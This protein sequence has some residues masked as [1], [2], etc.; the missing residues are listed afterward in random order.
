MVH[1]ASTIKKA[2]AI[3]MVLCTFAY[4]LM[5]GDFMV[6][7]SP[8]RFLSLPALLIL[9]CGA[10]FIR[11]R[12]GRSWAVAYLFALPIA[13]SFAG[14]MWI[15]RADPTLSILGCILIA[16]ALAMFAFI[17]GKRDRLWRVDDQQ[18]I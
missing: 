6:E 10:P 3:L 2:L 11:H 12:L 4:V 16:F 8:W 14:L 18:P 7:R 1:K 17:Y 15:S 13:M 5:L 9:S